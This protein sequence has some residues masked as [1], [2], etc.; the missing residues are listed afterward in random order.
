MP[1]TDR[2]CQLAADAVRA[3]LIDNPRTTFTPAQLLADI[4]YTLDC[5]DMFSIST[6]RAALRRLP[7]GCV[8]R[9]GNGRIEIHAR[10]GCRSSEFIPV[11]ERY[12]HLDN[13]PTYV[14]K[15]YPDICRELC[16]TGEYAVTQMIQWCA[17]GNWEFEYSYYGL[18]VRRLKPARKSA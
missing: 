11:L 8:T 18:W 3:M 1:R 10:G 2:K 14:K 7:D 5:D 15:H 16:L 9:R 12:L 17:P 6:L 13:V 4:N